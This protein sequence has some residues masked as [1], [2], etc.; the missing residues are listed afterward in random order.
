M[1]IVPPSDQ[2]GT[3]NGGKYTDNIS[4]FKLNILKLI[5]ARSRDFSTNVHEVAIL[6]FLNK[7]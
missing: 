5:Y 7:S 2:F 3:N 6:S 4:E 1:L